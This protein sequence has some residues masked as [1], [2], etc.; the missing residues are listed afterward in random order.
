MRDTTIA[1]DVEFFR[2]VL[3]DP[4]LQDALKRHALAPD[5]TTPA[6][7]IHNAVLIF[8]KTSW[9]LPL[10]A[11]QDKTL[12]IHWEART[13]HEFRLDVALDPYEGSIEKK[14]DL[15]QSLRPVLDF[16]ADLFQRL[17][18]EILDDAEARTRLGAN[19]SHLPAATAIR[20]QTVAKF[21][22]DLSADP[23]ASRS[24]QFFVE[25]IEALTPLVDHIAAESWKALTE[26]EK[27]NH[28]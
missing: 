5:P 11:G 20:A 13:R 15:A 3:R 26:H 1:D 10:L 9:V 4:A 18:R 21:D 19:T 23:T 28:L 16:K 8:C 7:S 22:R 27:E 17:R 2:Q 25:V 14:P 12:Q 6:A 24:A